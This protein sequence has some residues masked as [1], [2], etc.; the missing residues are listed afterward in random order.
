MTNDSYRLFLY[1][2]YPVKYSFSVWNSG[3]L[4][5]LCHHDP[6]FQ[7]SVNIFKCSAK[8]D[9]KTVNIVPNQCNFKHCRELHIDGKATCKFML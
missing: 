8:D 5:T 6:I 4:D 1:G 7:F 9:F 2:F 3:W